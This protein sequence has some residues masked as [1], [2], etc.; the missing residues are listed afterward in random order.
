MRISHT[1]GLQTPPYDGKQNIFLF[2]FKSNIRST[3][4]CT[5]CGWS[6]GRIFHSKKYACENCFCVWEG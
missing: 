3:H 1:P 4:V 5:W 6:V 2:I